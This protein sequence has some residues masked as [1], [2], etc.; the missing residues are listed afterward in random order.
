MSLWVVI[1]A[2]PLVR[3]KSR[4]STILSAEQRYEFAQGVLRQVLDVVTSLPEVVGTMVISRDPKILSIAREFGAKTIQEGR[5]STLNMALTRATVILKSWGVQ[6]ILVLPSDLPFVSTKDIHNLV[7]MGRKYN[8][9]VI[10]SDNAEDGTNALL[11][12]PP[13]IFPYCYGDNSYE[14]HIRLSR[15][16]GVE[17]RTYYSDSLALDIDLPSDLT[18]YNEIVST[19]NYKWLDTYYPEAAGEVE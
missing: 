9:V 3:A 2:K 11:M 17:P 14:E 16:A 1:P 10:A 5:N 12:R 15:E 7:N 19:G 6:A 4:L 8:S 18:L 13:G